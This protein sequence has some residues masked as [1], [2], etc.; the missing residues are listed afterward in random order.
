MKAQWAS[1]TILRVRFCR[2]FRELR[3]YNIGIA[4]ELPM[5]SAKSWLEER[6]VDS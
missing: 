1:W 4:L 2:K 3:D 5:D 6:W